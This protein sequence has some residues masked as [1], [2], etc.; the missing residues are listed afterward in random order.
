M[1]KKTASASVASA[2]DSKTSNNEGKKTMKKT[3]SVASASDFSA[4]S[5]LARK[6]AELKA[7]IAGKIEAIEKENAALM[8]I[9]NDMGGAASA[10]ASVS[11]S[12]SANGE[13]LTQKGTISKKPNRLDRAYSTPLSTKDWTKSLLSM[14]ESD[15][16]K[17]VYEKAKSD[18]ASLWTSLVSDKDVGK[19]AAK[20][21]KT[22]SRVKTEKDLISLVNRCKDQLLKDNKKDYGVLH[23]VMLLCSPVIFTTC[24][25]SYAMVESWDI[26]SKERAGNA[27]WGSVCN[28]RIPSKCAD[29]ARIIP[30]DRVCISVIRLSDCVTKS[31]KTYKKYDM[32]SHAVALIAKSCK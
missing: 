5:D 26:F 4:F 27:F 30:I 3:S 13:K 32:I 17:S 24:P 2:S 29:L 15:A 7:A 10:S 22:I 23:T 6:S 19:D 14:P 20:A 1:T 9:L 18:L 28:N 12:V 21:H 31:A 11:A 8:Q 25:T 16:A